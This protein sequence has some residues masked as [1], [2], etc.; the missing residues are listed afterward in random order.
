[1]SRAA[2]VRDVK[3]CLSTHSIPATSFVTKGGRGC[4]CTAAKLPELREYEAVDLGHDPGADREIG[5]AQAKHDQGRGNASRPAT[6][7]ANT[8]ANSG[9]SPAWMVKAKSR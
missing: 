9:S 2:E 3:Q 1:M 5:A 6:R 8:I 7:P 4:A